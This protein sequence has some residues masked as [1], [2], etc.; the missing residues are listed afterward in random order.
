VSDL[1]SKEYLWL[2]LVGG[3]ILLILGIR[4][5]RAR[6]RDPILP[7]D[8][9]GL[10]GSYVSA[11]ILALTNPVTIVAFIAVFAAFGLGRQLT[12][13]S[14]CILVLGVF[15]GS[16]LWFLTLGFVA[17]FFRKKLNRGGLKLVN[18]IA[19]VLIVLSGVAAFV[20]LL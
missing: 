15:A 4:T 5:F 14:A 7:F 10:L 16:L 6:R 17:T 3:G 20:S 11:F 19:G 2:H 12:M 18:K 9:K 8:N 1:I 13:I